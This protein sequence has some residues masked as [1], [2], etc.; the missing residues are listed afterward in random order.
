[1]SEKRFPSKDFYGPKYPR[2]FVYGFGKGVRGKSAPTQPQR[3]QIANSFTRTIHKG[4]RFT[5]MYV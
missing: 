3:S 1:M 4:I 2:K 5:G